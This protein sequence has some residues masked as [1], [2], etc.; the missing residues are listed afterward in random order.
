MVRLFRACA[1]LGVVVLV[2]TS[3]G[4][5]PGSVVRDQI[6]ACNDAKYS[7][8]ENYFDDDIK[9]ILH[10]PLGIL[11][12]G[13]KARCD[14]ATGYH[15]VESVEITKVET[16]GEG[17]T[18]TVVVRFKDKRAPQVVKTLIKEKGEW[19]ISG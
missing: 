15:Q 1:F 18:V 13:M 11:A 12:G 10:G 14:Q 16:L 19:K 5:S 9:G 3:C 17:S 4:K 2:C 7:E 6:M 8:A